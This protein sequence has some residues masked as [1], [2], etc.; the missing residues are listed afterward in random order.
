ML[1]CA[2]CKSGAGIIACGNAS[3]D[4]R[5]CTPEHAVLHWRAGHRQDHIGLPLRP[6]DESTTTHEVVTDANLNLLQELRASGL[7]LASVPGDERP[8]AVAGFINSGADG[9]VL[10]ALHDKIRRVIKLGITGPMREAVPLI[11]EGDLHDYLTTH[12]KWKFSSDLSSEERRPRGN[13]R[14]IVESI[15]RWVVETPLNMLLGEYIG[16]V[17]RPKDTLKPLVNKIAENANV[18]ADEPLLIAGQELEFV[19]MD[20]KKLMD[21]A[22]QSAPAYLAQVACIVAFL[23]ERGV[24]HN[25]LHLGNV[26]MRNM[27]HAVERV[28][29]VFRDGRKV[30][31]DA[32]KA[33]IMQMWF[34]FEVA[35]SDFGRSSGN[36]REDE[37]ARIEYGDEVVSYIEVW[38]R[39]AVP[40]AVR[41][42]INTPN[43]NNPGYD[44][45]RVAKDMIWWLNRHPD[46]HRP[47]GNFVRI[48]KLFLPT[49]QQVMQLR[50]VLRGAGD[51]IGLDSVLQKI[52]SAANSPALSGLS[53]A[54]KAIH[55]DATG[56]QRNNFQYIP[57]APRYWATPLQVVSE[58]KKRG[59]VHDDVADKNYVLVRWE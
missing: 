56:D 53:D 58:L 19:E 41:E 51:R 59:F 10:N 9:V 37:A 33:N 45:Y 1:N 14:P 54:V 32:P 48:L 42:L 29:V 28:G 46:V 22:P 6:V 40:K 44:L 8:L 21:E 18:S 12:I 17:Y 50:Q 16:H 15:D 31:V 4:M 3:C 49:P 7:Q 11:H 36:Y 52:V 47:D 39:L 26:R 27:K 30:F 5:Y 38:N 23:G 57:W 43:T 55:D 13:Y 20:M 25:D 35:L 24:V 34:R 2:H